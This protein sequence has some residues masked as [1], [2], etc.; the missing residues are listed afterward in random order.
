MDRLLERAAAAFGIERSFVDNEGQFVDNEGQL[1]VASPDT[2]RSLLGAMGVPAGSAGSLRAAL[3][4][5]AAEDA[6]PPLLVADAGADTAIMLPASTRGG[7]RL[8]L[9]AGDVLEGRLERGGR[10]ARLLLPE[11]LP[12]G[13]HRLHLERRDGT[14][15]SVLLVAAPSRCVSPAEIGVDQAFGIG[16]QIYG[17]RGSRDLGCGD[18]ADLQEFAA[19]AGDEGADFLALNPLHALFFSAPIDASPYAPSHRAFLNWLLIAPDRVAGAGVAPRGGS[20]GLVDY[21]ETAAL[22]RRMLDDAFARFAEDH[23]DNDS[24]TEGA[25]FRRF[26]AEGGEPLRRMALFEA[27]H[28]R[29]L[30]AE[31]RRWAWWDWPEGLRR[32]DGPDVAAFAREHRRRVAF[33]AWLQW[34][35]DGQLAV[36]QASCRDGGMRVGLYR[37]LAVGVNPAGCLA[38]AAQDVLVRRA[39]IG[40]PPDGFSPKGQNWGIA[41]LAPRALFRERL[42][43]WIAD[44]RANMRHAGALRIDHVMGLRRLFWV[45]EGGGPEDGAYVRYPLATMLAV[46]ALESHRARCLVVGEDL[47]TVPRGFRPALQRA[48][49]LASRVFYFERERNSAFSPARRYRAASVA[50]VGTHDLPS[51]RGFFEERD[52][53]WR[54]RLDLFPQAED[55]AEARCQR[56]R[57]RTR[58]VRLL[59]HSGLLAGE[60]DPPG[61][62]AIALALHRWLARTPAALFMVQLE[63]LALSPNSRTCRVP[64][65]GTPT[66]AAGS[67]AAWPSCW[68]ARSPAPCW[69]AFGASG[70][71][72]RRRA[73]GVRNRAGAPAFLCLRKVEQEEGRGWQLGDR[74]SQGARARHLPQHRPLRDG[75][76]CL[77][78]GL[79]QARDRAALRG[80]PAPPGRPDP[81]PAHARRPGPGGAPLGHRRGLV[82]PARGRRRAGVDRRRDRRAQAAPRAAPGARGRHAERARARAL[83]PALP[84]H[85]PAP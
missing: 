59:Q 53:D 9:E 73:R 83:E 55:A 41:P 77:L 63:D 39:S 52:I 43:P 50:S 11:P 4:A 5:A 12:A 81:L 34:L 84:A 33:F 80:P 48:G 44:I 7:W 13:Y 66:G 68:H 24:S 46:L 56:A 67:T 8:E 60:P 36:V 18:L 58:L 25:A 78:G 70:R 76:P 3:D 1:R 16:C 19:R 69:R 79:S 37:D 22:R 51:L 10:R 71:D 30:A 74:R 2:L 57:D 27:L 28:E 54:A 26:V 42:A 64:S 17:L 47:G 14:D 29:Q 65:T 72:R 75:E 6:L 38:W 45:P 35:A 62:E 23:L 31:P 61:L 21:P 49:V 85:P 20:S 32:P 15:G 40:A 82:R